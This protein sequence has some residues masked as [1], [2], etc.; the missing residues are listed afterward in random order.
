[1]PPGA[2]DRQRRGTRRDNRA[3]R[4]PGPPS[5]LTLDRPL[6]RPIVPVRRGHAGP[7]CLRNA[8]RCAG[9]RPAR[10]PTGSDLRGSGGVY[11]LLAVVRVAGLPARRQALIF[12]AAAV[13]TIVVGAA[14]IYL[15]ANWLSDALGGWA[16]GAMC[17]AFVIA[18]DVLITTRARR[19]ATGGKTR[20]I[21]DASLK[22]NGRKA[23]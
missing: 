21:G 13:I 20:P 2:R 4:R 22:G 1:H 9:C 8:G 6:R 7:G 17:I 3:A 16:L 18:A 14:S 23:A 19:Q 12:A 5:C 10:P 15:A 11:G